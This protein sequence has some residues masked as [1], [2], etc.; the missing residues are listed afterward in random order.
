MSFLLFLVEEKYFLLRNRCD[1]VVGDDNIFWCCFLI[2][3]FV[4]IKPGN[5]MLV[6]CFVCL[7]ACFCFC[8]WWIRD[9]HK[10]FG[11]FQTERCT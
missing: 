10:L 11:T 3:L 2:F 6:L 8:V 7:H 1:N 5:T 4:K 9:G